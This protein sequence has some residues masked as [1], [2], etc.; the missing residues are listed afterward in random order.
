MIEA[1]IFKTFGA[2]GL[3][4]MMGALIAVAVLAVLLGARKAGRTAERLD[5]LE[6][7]EKIYREQLQ[8]AANRPH[9][10]LELR[11]RLLDG[12]F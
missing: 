5:S 1:W 9:S 6:R 2:L 4:L 11:K 7:L 3:K 12:T 10:R 8:D